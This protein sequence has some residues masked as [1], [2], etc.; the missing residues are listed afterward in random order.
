MH[1]IYSCHVQSSYIDWIDSP[2]LSP[3]DSMGYVPPSLQSLSEIVASVLQFL[4]RIIEALQMHLLHTAPSHLHPGRPQERLPRTS[5][6]DSLRLNGEVISQRNLHTYNTAQSVVMEIQK[7]HD[8][9][10]LYMSQS[11]S[12]I[13]HIILWS[14]PYTDHHRSHHA[15]NYTMHRPNTTHFYCIILSAKHNS[16]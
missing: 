6:S 2:L 13:H 16:F 5:D 7:A 3:A 11:Y 12:N 1:A 4:S 9:R 14:I 15:L 8:T 10:L